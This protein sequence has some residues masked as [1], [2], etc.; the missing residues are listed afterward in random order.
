[1]SSS[2]IPLNEFIVK[3]A[4]TCNLNCSYCYIYN[5]G[6]STWKA[7]P[8]MMSD[9][10]FDLAVKRIRRHC[11]FSGQKSVVITFH[12]GEPF[13]IGSDRFDRWC[14]KAK[15]MLK[16]VAKIRF[17][18][19]TNGTLIDDDWIKVLLKHQVRIGISMDGP[20][21]LHDAFRVDHN[22]Q[23]SYQAVKQG[24]KLLQKA[25]IPFGILSVVQFGVD[26]LTV[27]RHFLALGTNYICYLL[28]AYTHDEIDS[29]HKCYGS[30]PCADFLIPIFD[31]W[32]FNSTIDIRI[33]EF[34]SI[35][36]LILG[37]SSGL[38]SLGN[39]PLQFVAI[40]TDGEIHGLDKLRVCKEGLTGT[41]LNIYINDFRDVIVS[42]S[43]HS[44]VIKGMPLPDDCNLC[45]ERDTCAGGYLPNRYSKE[46][47][48]NN[49]SV[50]CA[51][52]LRLFKHIR[53]RL[54]VSVEETKFRRQNLI[55]QKLDNLEIQ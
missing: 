38:D 15:D 3:V 13:L 45:P 4:S 27:H 41:H 47:E 11:S 21:H 51:D 32:W 48:F 42:D 25:N 24:V 8:P 17:A 10:T 28:P 9:D 50:W 34:W 29:I 2:D 40:E 1:M 18:V 7:R 43:L 20:E 46:R 49:P 30:T 53:N 35:A 16:G 44:Q 5:K 6:D 52:L 14:C 12:G 37:G 39:P 22:G 36:R 26:P 33:R 23:G 31:D 19:Q 54:G 55:H